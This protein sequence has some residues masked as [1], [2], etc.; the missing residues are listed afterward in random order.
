ME[1]QE[2][3]EHVKEQTIANKQPT[4][5]V[6]NVNVWALLSSATTTQA[7]VEQVLILAIYPNLYLAV[8]VENWATPIWVAVNGNM[9]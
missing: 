4:V 3:K 7:C 9:D 8:V 5:L 2:L 1:V 6:E